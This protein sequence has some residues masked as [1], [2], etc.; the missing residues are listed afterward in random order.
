MD[1]RGQPLLLRTR[2]VQGR[3]PLPRRARARLYFVLARPGADGG[4]PDARRAVFGGPAWSWVPEEVGRY[5][6]HRLQPRTARSRLDEPGP[7]AKDEL[8][9]QRGIGR[10]PDGTCIDLIGKDVDRGLYDSGRTLLTWSREMRA[11]DLPGPPTS[12]TS[13][14]AGTSP[15]DNVLD[16][17]GR[18]PDPP[19]TWCVSR[20]PRAR[21][22]GRRATASGG[23]CRSTRW[24]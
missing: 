17:C 4:P 24:C 18:R 3:Q 23:R 2:L 7:F 8:V 16:L 1:P 13:E 14:K 19:R 6:L 12:F 20:S 5:Y 22:L 11:K 21:R 15:S 9:G 10:L